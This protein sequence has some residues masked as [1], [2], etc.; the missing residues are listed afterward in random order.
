MGAETREQ[1]PRLLPTCILHPGTAV[2]PGARNPQ[3]CMYLGP[4]R[5]VGRL[6]CL[7]EDCLAS[8][9]SAEEVRTQDSGMGILLVLLR[10]LWVSAATFVK[11]SQS[12]PPPLPLPSW[13]SPSAFKGHEQKSHGFQD[14][15]CFSCYSLGSDNDYVQ[16]HLKMGE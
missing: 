6:S 7:Q 13:R 3:S 2:V 1:N 16:L 14:S 4:R 8:P 9:E 12:L 15:P 5:Q 11:G 10:W